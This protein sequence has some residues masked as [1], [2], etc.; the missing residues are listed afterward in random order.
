VLTCIW[1]TPSGDSLFNDHPLA[2]STPGAGV[3]H[4]ITRVNFRPFWKDFETL[5]DLIFTR[6]GWQ[7]VGALGGNQADVDL[8]LKQPISGE[9]AW[10]QVKLRSSQAEFDDYLGRFERNGRFDRFFFIY[11]SATTPIRMRQQRQHHLW[12]VDQGL[13][14]WLLERTT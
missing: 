1:T 5:I 2:H 10:V 7:R 9:T 3:V 13:L 11:H 12:S 14:T 4:S 8:V 6:G